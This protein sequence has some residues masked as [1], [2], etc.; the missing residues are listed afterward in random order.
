MEIWYQQQYIGFLIIILIISL[1]E[2]GVLFSTILAC[3]KLRKRRKD[4]GSFIIKPLNNKNTENIY[5]NKMFT[6][7][8]PVTDTYIQPDT[9]YSPGSKLH[10]HYNSKR[11]EMA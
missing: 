2:F 3:V 4:S 5:H 6:I 10:H 8:R 9:F 11:D 1:V 7:E